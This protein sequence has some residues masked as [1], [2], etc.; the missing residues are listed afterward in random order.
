M[1]WKFLSAWV[2]GLVVSG[3]IHLPYATCKSFYF[4][5][6]VAPASLLTNYETYQVYGFHTPAV[7]PLQLVSQAAPLL[8][9]H[10][11]LLSQRC[12]TIPVAACVII[13]YS[14]EK[15]IVDNHTSVS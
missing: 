7:V 3:G 14:L 12:V 4:L 6:E 9:S 10:Y 15:A 5:S 8:S 2:Q 11:L 1:K 13:L